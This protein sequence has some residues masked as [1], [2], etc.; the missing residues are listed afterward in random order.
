VS[1]LLAVRGEDASANPS[2]H[3]AVRGHLGRVP[4]KATPGPE[5]GPDL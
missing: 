3:V 4:R 2:G 5:A 1:A